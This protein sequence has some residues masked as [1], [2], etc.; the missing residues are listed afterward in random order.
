MPRTSL[1]AAAFVSAILFAFPATAPAQVAASSAQQIFFDAFELLRQADYEKAE[2]GFRKGLAIEPDNARARLLL[3]DALRGKK[4][5]AGA[6]AAYEEAARKGAPDIAHQARQR[7]A[8]LPAAAAAS[9]TVAQDPD[10]ARASLLKAVALVRQPS[11]TPRDVPMVLELAQ[12]LTEL[13]DRAQALEVLKIAIDN[14]LLVAKASAGSFGGSSDRDVAA[15]LARA[16]RDQWKAGDAPAAGRTLT[17]AEGIAR[18]IR[19]SNTEDA[20]ASA[21]TYVALGYAAVG[22][23]RNADRVYNDAL[24]VAD[25]ADEGSQSDVRAQIAIARFRAG[26]VKGAFSL[27]PLVKQRHP[28]FFVGHSWPAVMSAMATAEAN[29]GHYDRA[30]QLISRGADDTGISS[31]STYLDIVRDAIE[32]ERFQAAEDLVPRMTSDDKRFDALNAIALAY[33]A[34]NRKADVQRMLN[35]LREFGEGSAGSEPTKVERD[36]VQETL[37]AVLVYMGLRD[38]AEKRAAAAKHKSEA[39]A[40]LARGYALT[41][42]HETAFKLLAAI[43]KDE[44]Y[45]RNDVLKAMAQ[46]CAIADVACAMKVMQS[47][48][49]PDYTYADVLK[50]RAKAGDWESPLKLGAALEAW[51]PAPAGQDPD[52]NMI[53][54][55]LREAAAEVAKLGRCD[56][57]LRYTKYTEN[58][59]VFWTLVGRCQAGLPVVTLEDTR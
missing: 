5:L 35:R 19:G 47:P 57:A 4:D 22:D 8:Q 53:Q 26:D 39:L 44:D 15:W 30:V 37:P 38:E 31:S 17:A 49:F 51:K 21:L 6:R 20:R 48:Q 29:A 32:K 28:R 3:G 16:A 24:A 42:D 10:K 14:A 36:H 25:R 33:A 9:T 58:D 13:G 52:E 50:S 11:K 46:D 12:A 56:D 40:A 1:V 55:S 34:R 41:G 2:A 54:Y 23:T 59:F 18:G 43:P 7:I 45:R 27:E